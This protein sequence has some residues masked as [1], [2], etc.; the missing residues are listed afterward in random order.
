MHCP[1]RSNHFTA[2]GRWNPKPS[3]NPSRFSGQISL[4]ASPEQ[5]KNVSLHCQ[6]PPLQVQAD[7]A[8]W[9]ILLPFCSLD[10]GSHSAEWVQQIRLI[11]SSLPVSSE[12]C[13]I[14]GA[15]SFWSPWSGTR[16]AGVR[17]FPLFLVGLGRWIGRDWW[18]WRFWWW[19]FRG[20]RWWRW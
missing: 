16:A 4:F 8:P 2:D 17:S 6:P 10:P 19:A 18:L 11:L 13:P 7:G 3:R 14:I 12:S 15:E 5:Y 20:K 1:L 9:K